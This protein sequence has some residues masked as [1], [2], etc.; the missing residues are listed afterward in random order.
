MLL[1]D[2]H[3]LLWT[4][5]ETDKL[6]F[7]A[8]R[9]ISQNQCCISIVSLWEMAVK[10]SL[11]REEKRLVLDRSILSFAELC[12]SYDIEILPVTPLDCEQVTKLAHIHSDPF[13]RM[14]VAQAMTR[15]IPLVTKDKN[16]W[17]YEGIEKI[18]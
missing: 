5:N 6:S 2:T 13:D 15:N 12:Q 10:A 8:H 14:I 1:L 7:T 9:A 4:L 16:I 18:W 11:V 17:K 3:V